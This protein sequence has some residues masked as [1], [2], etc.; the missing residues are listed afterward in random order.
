MLHPDICVGSA[1]G[2][3]GSGLVAT[4]RIPSGAVIWQL[5]PHATPIPESEL[6]KR[7]KEDHRNAFTYRDDTAVVTTDGFCYF[8]HC[9]NPNTWWANDETLVARR[10]I[11]P[12][13]EV[14]FDYATLDVHDWWRPKWRCRCGAATC[15]GYVTGRDCLGPWF[16]ER[17][18]DH[19]PSWVADYIARNTGL[20]RWRSALAY[21]AAELIRA[22]R[23]I[24]GPADIRWY[25]LHLPGAS[26]P[27]APSA[28]PSPSPGP[29]VSS[30]ERSED[31]ERTS[32]R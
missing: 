32:A 13:E 11:L 1:S 9:C 21:L 14:T 27:E 28:D 4:R 25:E 2:I 10:D 3:D 26:R 16:R 20:R 22:C 30:P 31:A 12:G 17:Y 19:V 7:P 29:V 5:D 24:L 8:N 15:R 23:R 18:G 6:L